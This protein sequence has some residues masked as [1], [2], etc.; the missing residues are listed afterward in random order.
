MYY[1][2]KLHLYGFELHLHGNPAVEYKMTVKSF[3][4][5]HFMPAV[6]LSHPL[7]VFMSITSRSL[8]DQ[9]ITMR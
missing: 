9:C 1:E 6:T 2:I 5:C 7:C 8:V 4:I 3:I